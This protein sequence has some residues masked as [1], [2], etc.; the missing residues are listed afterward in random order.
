[1]SL[2]IYNALETIECTWAILDFIMLAKYVL[3]NNK[4]LQYIDH[5]LYRLENTKIAFG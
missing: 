3:Y 1:M 5:A 2:L 4:T